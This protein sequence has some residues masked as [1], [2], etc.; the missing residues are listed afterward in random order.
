M[1]GGGLFQYIMSMIVWEI[2]LTEIGYILKIS[3]KKV[4]LCTVT[5]QQETGKLGGIVRNGRA[6]GIVRNGRAGGIVRNGQAGGIVRNGQ[7]GGIL[8]QRCNN[9]LL[10]L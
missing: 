4:F 8:C 5:C 9:I 6:G 3:V 7:A 1:G 10:F 2:F